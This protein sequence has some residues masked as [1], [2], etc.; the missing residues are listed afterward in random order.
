MY[1]YIYEFVLYILMYIYIYTHYTYTCI[2]IMYIYIYTHH[3]DNLSKK[4]HHHLKADEHLICRLPPVPD[5]SVCSISSIQRSEPNYKH[6]IVKGFWLV[7]SNP[8]KTISQL[9]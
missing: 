3:I 6:R 4:I 1:I 7:V 8:L 2:H 5:L 9:G